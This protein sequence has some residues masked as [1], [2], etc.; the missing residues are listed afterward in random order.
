MILKTLESFHEFKNL[1]ILFVNIE[2]N[3]QYKQIW[4]TLTSESD[5]G[6]FSDLQIWHQKRNV[7]AIWTKYSANRLNKRM[8][9]YL[10]INDNT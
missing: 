6:V 7:R 5:L 2:K 8:T 3:K 4:K 9:M 1:R 10:Q